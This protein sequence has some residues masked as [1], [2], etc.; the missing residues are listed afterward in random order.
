MA[1]PDKKKKS[2]LKSS[3][4]PQIAAVQ[5]S[6]FKNFMVKEEKILTPSEF[7]D[8]IKDPKRKKT[9]IKMYKKYLK[10]INKDKIPF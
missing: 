3:M 6:G 1:I 10:D 8:F 5:D 4:Q 7:T 9:V 2:L